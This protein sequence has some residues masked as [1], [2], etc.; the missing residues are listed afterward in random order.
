[1]MFRL[2]SWAMIRLYGGDGMMALLFAERVILGKTAWEDVPNS[3]KAQT[4]AELK[5]SGAEHL[6]GDYVPGK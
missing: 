2:L 3:L 5:I 1:M 4:Y 6:A